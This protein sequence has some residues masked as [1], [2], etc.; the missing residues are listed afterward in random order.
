MNGLI[1]KWSRRAQR[2]ARSCRRGTP[3]TC[4]VRRTLGRT[5][6]RRMT[7]SLAV[8]AIL[9]AWQASSSKVL[10]ECIALRESLAERVTRSQLVFLGEVLSIENIL[11]P[12][13]YRYRVRFRVMESFRGLGKGEQVVQFRPSAEDFK[14]DVSQRVLVYATGARDQYSTQCTATRLADA[15][16]FE[17]RE[18]RRLA[19]K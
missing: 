9:C 2:S 10:A 3:L 12:E 7:A 11:Q 5:N 15:D 17:V 14:C 13:S 19:R 16:D 4:D 18:L 8:F 1:R 6:M